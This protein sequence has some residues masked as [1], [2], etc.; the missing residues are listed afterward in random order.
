[1]TK[2]INES[3]TLTKHISCK[4]E[5]KCDIIKYISNDKCNNDKFQCESKKPKEHN[6][7]EK[8]YIWNS[9][10]WSCKNGKYSE[11]FIGDSVIT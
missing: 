1:M 3:K 9:A 6:A 11:S 5:C 8:D 2:G 4:C 10:S 7:F